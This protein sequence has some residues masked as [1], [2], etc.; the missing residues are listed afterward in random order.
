MHSRLADS[1]FTCLAIPFCQAATLHVLAE[2][3]RPRTR[4][5]QRLSN[6][7]ED[8][9]PHHVVLRNGLEAMLAPTLFPL[10]RN[11]NLSP[12]GATAIGKAL[13]AVTSLTSLEMGYR[14]PSPVSNPF[15][16]R[17]LFRSSTVS[18]PRCSTI[19]L[20]KNHPLMPSP[21]HH[22]IFSSS[23]SRC[24]PPPEFWLG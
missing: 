23:Y 16:G 13:N 2:P 7:I 20:S 24:T 4:V 12:A 1:L 14:G 18:M 10:N 3:M 11:N 5:L 22:I 21:P 9:V 15:F 17:Y 6:S 19:G 8:G